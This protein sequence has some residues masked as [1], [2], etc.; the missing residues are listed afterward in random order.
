MSMDFQ[1]RVEEAASALATTARFETFDEDDV[2]ATLEIAVEPGRHQGVTLA[3]DHSEGVSF[4][5]VTTTVGESRGLDGEQLRKLMVLNSS[6]LYGTFAISDGALVLTGTVETEAS[7]AHLAKCI[8][9][10]ARKGDQFQK[11][12]FGHDRH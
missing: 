7:T 4:L 5:R 1:A 6:L 8:E 3:P 11:M 12:F 10:I 9:V 2:E